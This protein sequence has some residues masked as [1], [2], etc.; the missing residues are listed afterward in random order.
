MGVTQKQIDEYI[1]THH[2]VPVNEMVTLRRRLR[3]AEA[4]I[5]M[6]CRAFGV[7]PGCGKPGRDDYRTARAKLKA[8]REAGDGD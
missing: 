3:E 7:P 4:V 5:E 1:A 2:V 8:W 6:C